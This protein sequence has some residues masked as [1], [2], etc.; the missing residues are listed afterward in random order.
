MQSKGGRE[1]DNLVGPTLDHLLLEVICVG[2]AMK[3]PP[4]A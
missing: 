3:Q 1:R 4:D 2:L